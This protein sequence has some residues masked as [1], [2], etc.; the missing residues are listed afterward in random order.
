MRALT[1]A[2]IKRSASVMIAAVKTSGRHPGQASASERR[3]G[4]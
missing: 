1:A 3:A 4:A 2:R